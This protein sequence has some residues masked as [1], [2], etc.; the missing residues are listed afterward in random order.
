MS[1]VLTQI[2][3][4]LDPSSP[5]DDQLKLRALGG[6]GSKAPGPDSNIRKLTEIGHQRS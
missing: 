3:S 4:G 5:N 2:C 6:I 1:L